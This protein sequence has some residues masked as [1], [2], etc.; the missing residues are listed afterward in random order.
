MKTEKIRMPLNGY[1]VCAVVVVLIIYTLNSKEVLIAAALI[2]FAIFLIKG[3]IVIGP[4][5]SKV[6]LLFG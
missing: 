6:F 2:P 1:F 5:S 3:L 4:N